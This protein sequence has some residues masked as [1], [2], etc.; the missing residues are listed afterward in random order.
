MKEYEFKINGMQCAGC[1]NIIESAAKTVDGVDEV[2]VNHENGIMVFSASDPTAQ[3]YVMEEIE[4]RGY[5]VSGVG[6]L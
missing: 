5:E 1:E 6:S 3:K 2:T 4:E